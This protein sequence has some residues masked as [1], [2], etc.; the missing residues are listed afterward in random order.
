[1]KRNHHRLGIALATCAI[2]SAWSQLI[3]PGFKQVAYTDAEM[4]KPVATLHMPGPYGNNLGSLFKGYLMVPFAPDHMLPGGGLRFYDLSDP[5]SPK[6]VSTLNTPESQ[7]F[8]EAHGYGAC[9]NYPGAD[10]AVFQARQGI[11]FWNLTDVRNPVLVN[12]MTLPTINGSGYDN[13]VFSVFW[14]APY[15]YTAS[16]A[17]GV[18]IVDAKNPAN[19][20]FVKQIPMGQTGNFR[21]GL[22]FAVGNLLVLSIVG[23][24]STSAGYSFFDIS[25]PENPKFLSALVNPPAIYSS[26][27]N[28][29]R[30]YGT[31]LDGKM[32]VHDISDPRNVKLAWSTEKLSDAHGEY[33]YI[34]DHYAFCDFEVEALKVDLNTR[35]VVGKPMMSLGE[36]QEGHPVPIGNYLIVGD[37]HSIGSGVIPHQQ[38]PDVTGPSVNMVNPPD[39]AVNQALTSR[40]GITM[41][42]LLD[43]SS[44]NT[45]TFI[46]REAGGTALPGKY[47]GQTEILNFFPDAPL[48]PGTEYEVVVPQGGI[49]DVVGN[50]TPTAFISKFRTAGVSSVNARAAS[51]RQAKNARMRDIE[52]RLL[53]IAAGH[54]KSTPVFAVPETRGSRAQ[55]E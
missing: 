33:V 30:I 6:I 44:V 25:D 19:P 39:G 4:Y 47:S 8:V 16:S 45:G 51:M 13:G 43:L 24:E 14:Q 20:R 49:K 40:V 32:Y 22:I 15:V 12:K 42:D 29:N 36:A 53:P 31:G 50:P 41:T 46:V 55:G 11:Q 37:D 48:K 52:G 54:R 7:D 3:G 27:V 35:K 2:T 21:V 28:G 38:T 34:Q 26:L 17:H 23:L 1:M 5:R 18:H 9:Y 10:Y